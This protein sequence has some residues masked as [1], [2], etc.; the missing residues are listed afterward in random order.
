MCIFIVMSKE[1]NTEMQK[2]EVLQGALDLMALKVLDALGLRHGYGVARG[3]EQ[4]LQRL[5]G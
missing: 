5:E 2:S 4:V 1:Q 3:I